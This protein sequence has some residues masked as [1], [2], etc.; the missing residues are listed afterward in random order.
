MFLIGVVVFAIAS[1]L[2][3][4]SPSQGSS[5]AF[6]AL[7]GAGRGADDARDPSIITNAFPPSDRGK[8]IGT[9]GGVSAIALALCSLVG[10]WLTEDVTCFSRSRLRR[11][12][13]R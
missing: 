2:I 12:P 13:S 6:L 8:A 11:S 5:I 1:A 10:G 3:G 7:Q 4:V 9:L